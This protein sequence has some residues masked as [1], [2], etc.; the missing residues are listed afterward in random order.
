MFEDPDKEFQLTATASTGPNLF[1]KSPVWFSSYK[2]SV[3]LFLPLFKPYLEVKVKILLRPS[4]CKVISVLPCF[5]IDTVN[6]RI[7]EK[8]S[9]ESLHFSDTLTLKSDPIAGKYFA[10]HYGKKCRGCFSRYDRHTIKIVDQINLQWTSCLV[11]QVLPEKFRKKNMFKKD[12]R[13]QTVCR[14]FF[15]VT[16]PRN[17]NFNGY[18]M[19]NFS[20]KD[21]SKTAILSNSEDSSKYYTNDRTAV[22]FDLAGK[23]AMIK[24]VMDLDY[25]LS[26]TA[27]VVQNVDKDASGN[28]KFQMARIKE[29]PHEIMVLLWSILRINVLKRIK[30]INQCKKIDITV[31][32][33]SHAN[34]TTT[35]CKG[36]LVIL[37]FYRGH[38]EI[39]STRKQKPRYQKYFIQLCTFVDFAC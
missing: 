22:S 39:P 36:A 23:L 20:P 18:N 34:N 2:K 27:L 11:L 37:Y 1:R 10:Y 14:H 4:A 33:N 24:V 19:K 26:P 9:T 16:G 28:F 7:K 5:D 35:A 30:V 6:R 3:Q 31:L 21:K 17:V 8:I 25:F 12:R 13:I 15:I 32:P 29:N 38:H